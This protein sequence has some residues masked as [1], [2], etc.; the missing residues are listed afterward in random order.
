M[1]RRRDNWFEH[2]LRRAK[3]QPQRQVVA[4]GALGFFIALILGAL[5][6]SQVAAE[7]TMNRHLTDL[8]EVRDELERNNEQLRAEIAGLRSVPALRARAIALGFSDA[9][10][11]QIEYLPV[12]GYNPQRAD[13]VAPIGLEGGEPSV[14]DETFA[15]WIQQQWEA[16]QDSLNDLLGRG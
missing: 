4:L 15:G 11:G 7:V 8:L 13:T 1:I 14:Y 10:R 12:Q 16:L 9:Q 5:Y 6:L 2:A 3:W